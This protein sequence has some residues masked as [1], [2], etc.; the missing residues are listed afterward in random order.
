M[1][2]PGFAI[3]SWGVSVVLGG[4]LGLGAWQ[5]SF[6]VEALRVRALMDGWLGQL[7]LLL[8]PDTFGI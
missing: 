6:P 1:L 4:L 8:G 7:G 5:H 2:R 3:A